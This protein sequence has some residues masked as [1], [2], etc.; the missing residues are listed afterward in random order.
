MLLGEVRRE[1]L[2]SGGLSK[3]EIHQKM[4][5]S[6]S[7]ENLHDVLFKGNEFRDDKSWN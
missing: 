7:T 2:V 4:R 6:L 3:N 5:E 1:G